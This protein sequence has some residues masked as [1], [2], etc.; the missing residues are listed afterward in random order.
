MTTL[1]A[2]ALLMR[3]TFSFSVMDN[4]EAELL[5]RYF[6]LHGVDS[7][8]FGG[9]GTVLVAKTTEPRAQ[10]LMRTFES[11][12]GVAYSPTFPSEIVKRIGANFVISEK[13][14]GSWA[15][16]NGLAPNSLVA[17]AFRQ[18]VKEGK[19]PRSGDVTQCRYCLR[20]WIDDKLRRT[21]AIDGWFDIQDSP[22]GPARFFIER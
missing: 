12:F 10:Q 9:E 14:V 22:A 21:D 7:D 13:D 20:P 19:I 1:L 8:L 11:E 18:C 5:G 3:P 15:G 2:L 6:S 16:G 4:Q 17:L